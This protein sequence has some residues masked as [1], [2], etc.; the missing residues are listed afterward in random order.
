MRDIRRFTNVL[1]GT[2]ALIG[3]EV[4]LADVLAI[5]AL[6]V[7]APAS[8]ALIV[9][10][11]E[12]LTRPAGRLARQS[13]ETAR[14]QVEAIVASAGG[15]AD[16]VAEIIKTLFPAAAG[17][18]GGVSYG[19][20]W[21][22]NWREAARIAHPEVLDIYLAKA[23]PP[24][25]LPAD[26]VQ[27]ALKSLEDE[28]ALITLLNAL[29]DEQLE[30]LLRRLE[31]YE[32]AFASIR[33]ELAIA[34]LF[35]Q[36]RRLERPRRYALD[37]GAEHRVPRLVLRLLR[38]RDPEDVA[39]IIETALPGILT[40]SERGHLIRMVGYHE[41][42]GHELV[43]REHAMRLESE[44][45]D[46][47]IRSHAS[48]L[49]NEADILRLLFWA[50]E[51]RPRETRACIERLIAVDEFLLAFLS[52]ALHESVAQ[53][54]GQAAVYRTQEFDWDTL[55]AL[56]DES[57]LINRVRQL[58]T[59]AVW[60]HLTEHTRQALRYALERVDLAGG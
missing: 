26:V 42:S 4:E 29:D 22:G 5:E 9:A 59:P 35:N 17:Y 16:E 56:V 28:Q 60:E 36:H 12:A 58:N 27:R 21:L 45:L 24:G 52:A 43:S 38:R 20:E 19:S 51:A 15:F 50:Q 6:R 2:L 55:I 7:R 39:R 31:H 46:E 8:F 13:S 47:L 53:T 34:V 44:F 3:A 1:P 32:D 23:L 40:L 41:N 14:E 49:A 54:I 33:P 18:L 25:A 48:L 10:A 37:I 30:T 57:I 11:R